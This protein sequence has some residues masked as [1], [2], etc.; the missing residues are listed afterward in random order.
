MVNADGCEYGWVNRGYGQ[1]VDGLG[2][3]KRVYDLRWICLH[4]RGLSAS[5]AWVSGRS[6]EMGAAEHTADSLP[7]CTLRT[8]IR[9]SQATQTSGSPLGAWDHTRLLYLICYK[10]AQD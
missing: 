2:S 9:A 8:L 3:V 6:W 10:K 4:R 1:V 7:V 5:V